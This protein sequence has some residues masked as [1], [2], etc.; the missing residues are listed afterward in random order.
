MHAFLTDR[1]KLERIQKN[2]MLQQIIQQER[3]R[4]DRL[5]VQM[6]EK[7]RKQVN[8][9]LEQAAIKIQ[10]VFR[11]KREGKTMILHIKDL[12]KRLLEEERARVKLNDTIVSMQDETAKYWFSYLQKNIDVRFHSV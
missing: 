12:M 3:A 7:K 1:R 11:R 8:D 2:L 4:I 5:K 6:E 9:K 10:R